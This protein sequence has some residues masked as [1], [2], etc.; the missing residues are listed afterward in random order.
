MKGK[1]PKKYKTLPIR[2]PWLYTPFRG[3]GGKQKTASRGGFLI[4]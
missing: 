2:A 3:L 4:L 1:E